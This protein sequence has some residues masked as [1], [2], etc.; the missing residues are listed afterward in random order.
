MKSGI[1]KM[2]LEKLGIE[3]SRKTNDQTLLFAMLL[4]IKTNIISHSFA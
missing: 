2:C 3:E 1:E 4:A